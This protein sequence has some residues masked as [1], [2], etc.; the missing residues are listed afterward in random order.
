MDEL[1]E[2]ARHGDRIAAATLEETLD[3]LAWRGGRG[4]FPS[5]PPTPQDRAWIDSCLRL[6]WDKRW[7][8][9]ARAVLTHLPPNEIDMARLRRQVDQEGRFK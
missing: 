3:R 4:E 7:G 8:A 9:R 5:K 6:V 2:R 1:L